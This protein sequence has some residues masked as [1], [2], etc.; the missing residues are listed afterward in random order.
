MLFRIKH[1]RIILLHHLYRCMFVLFIEL[2]QREGSQATLYSQHIL[3]VIMDISWHMVRKHRG[4]DLSSATAVG[5]MMLL[6][7]K[8]S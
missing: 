1:T 5:A 3:G 4:K 7:G 2:M 8:G 6:R